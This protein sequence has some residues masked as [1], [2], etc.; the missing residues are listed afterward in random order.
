ML[1]AGRG[2]MLAAGRGY[3]LAAGRGYMLAA[4]RGYMLVEHYSD[5]PECTERGHTTGAEGELRIP[6]RLGT[7]RGYFIH[8]S[9]LGGI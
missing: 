1:A 7:P 4:G 6:W 8:L 9:P 3:M 2:Y 5:R